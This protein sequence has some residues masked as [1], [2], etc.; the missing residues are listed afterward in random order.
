[1]AAEY[2]DE[3]IKL[4]QLFYAISQLATFDDPSSEE[5]QEFFHDVML[6]DP[7]DI[8]AAMAD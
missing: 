1:M 2:S 6:A 8:R 5:A 4:H 3:D 7:D